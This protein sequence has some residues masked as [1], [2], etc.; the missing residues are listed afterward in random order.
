MKTN[1][2]CR[3]V[4]G[5][6]WGRVNSWAPKVFYSVEEAVDYWNKEYKNRN[7]GDEYDA[8]WRKTPLRIQLVT[9]TDL[10]DENDL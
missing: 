7:K 8:K 10:W 2:T 6:L 9:K 5:L 4:T 3:L 1:I